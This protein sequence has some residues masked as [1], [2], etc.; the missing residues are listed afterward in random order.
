MK[1]ASSSKEMTPSGL[2]KTFNL[3]SF[4][5]L[6]TITYT[7]LITI[8]VQPSLGSFDTLNTSGWGDFGCL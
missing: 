2:L 8:P 6:S 5:Y 4:D 3:F 7:K 1:A